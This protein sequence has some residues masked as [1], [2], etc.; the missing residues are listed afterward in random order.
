MQFNLIFTLA[1]VFFSIQPAHA[2][3]DPSAGGYIVQALFGVFLS[4]SMVMKSW[5]SSK[6][7]D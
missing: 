5:L 3:I 6:K 1:L 4:A 7:R 2:Y